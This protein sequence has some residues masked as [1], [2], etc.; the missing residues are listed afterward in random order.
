M[1]YPSAGGT[2]CRNF[3]Q[4]LNPLILIWERHLRT[5]IAEESAGLNFLELR[6]LHTL[7]PG[8][9][10]AAYHPYPAADLNSTLCYHRIHKLESLAIAEFAVPLAKEE[11]LK[12]WAAVMEGNNIAVALAALKLTRLVALRRRSSAALDSYPLALQPMNSQDE[13]LQSSVANTPGSRLLCLEL[14]EKGKNQTGW[15]SPPV[16]ATPKDPPPFAQVLVEVDRLLS[17]PWRRKSSLR[18]GG[19]LV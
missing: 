5:R 13:F 1:H 19:W 4:D 8:C 10:V 2:G 11:G 15:R 17:E 14:P 18:V 16:Q 7:F 9:T 3:P 6:I 12:A